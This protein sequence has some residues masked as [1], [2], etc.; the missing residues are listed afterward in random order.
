MDSLQAHGVDTRCVEV[1]DRPTGQVHVTLDAAGHASYEFAVDTAWDS[2][3]GPTVCSN[4]RI[5][6]TRSVLARWGSGAK[7]RGRR[8]CD[9]CAGCRQSVCGC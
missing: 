3:F 4:W 9:L 7:R 8:F 6:P 2:S 5:G 1:I